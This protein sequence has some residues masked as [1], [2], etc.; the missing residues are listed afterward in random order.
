M[1]FKLPYGH[2]Q[3]VEFDVPDR[4]VVFFVERKKLPAV[5]DVGQSVSEALKKPIGIPAFDRMAKKGDKVVVI[6]DDLTRPTPQKEIC[7]QSWSSS[8]RIE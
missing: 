8:A 1:H 2:N 6:V 3:S 7:P 5:R 4:N